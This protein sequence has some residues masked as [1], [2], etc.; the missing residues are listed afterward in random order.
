MFRYIED[1]DVFLK[2]YAYMLARR[3]VQQSF[4]SD[5]A[6]ASMISKLKVR[7][8]SDHNTSTVA[9]MIKISTF[10]LVIPICL[11]LIKSTA[12]PSRA[13]IGPTKCFCF[14]EINLSLGPLYM[15]VITYVGQ[16]YIN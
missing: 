10:Y 11:Y 12:E 9:S 2:F 6:E 14:K 1:K 15:Y 13:Y 4:I 5:D 8:Y 3:L 16:A 7:T